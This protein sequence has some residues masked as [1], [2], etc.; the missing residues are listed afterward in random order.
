MSYVWKNNST[1]C[2]A[3]DIDKLT[4]FQRQKLLLHYNGVRR[5]IDY[6]L[7]YS[8]SPTA[9]FKHNVEGGFPTG[10]VVY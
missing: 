6:Y 2:C 8:R 3:L 9:Y 1:P 5:G 4:L 10:I 7:A